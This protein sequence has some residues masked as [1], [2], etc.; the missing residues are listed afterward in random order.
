MTP[1]PISENTFTDDQVEA[2]GRYQYAVT[3]LDRTGNE[4]GRSEVLTETG[5]GAGS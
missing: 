5:K 1:A 2:G 3:A 4:S